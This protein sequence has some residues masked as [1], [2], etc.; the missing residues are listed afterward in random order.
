[1]I[2][3]L[4]LEVLK[5]SSDAWTD[6]LLE[7]FIKLGKKVIIWLNLLTIFFVFRHVFEVLDLIL[8]V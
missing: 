6:V 4:Q 1:M 7:D 5:F 3:L 2:F 8:V